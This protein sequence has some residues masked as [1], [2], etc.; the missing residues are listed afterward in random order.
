M[1]QSYDCIQA[2]VLLNEQTG[3]GCGDE[4]Q[5]VCLNNEIFGFCGILCITVGDV[6]I[7]N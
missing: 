5:N 3:N 4:T 7:F 6:C 2:K 1:S